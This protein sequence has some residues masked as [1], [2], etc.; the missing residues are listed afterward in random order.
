MLNLNQGSVERDNNKEIEIDEQME[1]EFRVHSSNASPLQ[2]KNM[3][4]THKNPNTSIQSEIESPSRLDN[5]YQEAQ[6]AANNIRKSTET[7]EVYD[8]AL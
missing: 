6:A 8:G 7:P 1:E 4:G 3:D 2:P 5:R